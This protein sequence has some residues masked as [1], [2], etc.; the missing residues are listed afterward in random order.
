LKPYL[1]VMKRNK[2]FGLSFLALV[3]FLPMIHA[4]DN[5]AKAMFIYN[6]IRYIE[7]PANNSK[8]EIVVGVYGS[9]T[10]YS[11]L[12][13]LADEHMTSNRP[14]VVKFIFN[15]RELSSCN[16]VFVSEE[17]SDNI[18]EVYAI[19]K[20]KAIV[21]ITDKPGMARTYS[22]INLFDNAGKLGFEVNRKNMEKEGIKVNATLYK[23]GKEI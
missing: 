22:A 12:K 4:Q 3:L 15:T 17:R 16:L 21:L 10:V 19:C 23:L 2:K 1:Q 18:D 6:F 20:N 13:T 11:D 9:S 7:W 5:K 14:V 8:G